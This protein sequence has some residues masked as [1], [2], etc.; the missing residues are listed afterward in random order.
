MSKDNNGY[1]VSYI[2]DQALKLSLKV[3][4][5]LSPAKI[6]DKLCEDLPDSLDEAQRIAFDSYVQENI[7]QIRDG[8]MREVAAHFRGYSYIRP[9]SR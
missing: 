1:G 9:V 3:A 6:A 2:E 8:L 4:S 5:Q 7:A